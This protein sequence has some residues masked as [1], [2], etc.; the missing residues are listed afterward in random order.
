MPVFIYH[1]L[2]T[3]GKQLKDAFDEDGFTYV[4]RPQL[5]LIIQDK[6][7]KAGI[8]VT[9]QFY[10]HLGPMGYQSLFDMI[11]KNIQLDPDIDMHKQ[12]LNS[13]KMKKP[14]AFVKL[15]NG[16]DMKCVIG[17]CNSDPSTPFLMTNAQ[18]AQKG[19]IQTSFV[20]R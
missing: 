11:D 10:C 19:I 6:M 18:M 2:N 20:P 15:N 17:Y 16:P 12:I 7:T 14:W 9:P 5:E 4:A 8:E 13:F 3:I 1:P